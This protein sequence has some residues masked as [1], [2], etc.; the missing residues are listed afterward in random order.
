MSVL[1]NS[2]CI[3]LSFILINTLTSFT[4]RGC[5]ATLCK[6]K[7][8]VVIDVGSVKK[9][10]IRMRYDFNEMACTKN[11][12]QYWALEIS[13]DLPMFDI[14][15][16]L[17]LTFGLHFKKQTERPS[18]LR[19]R[20]NGRT[21]FITVRETPNFLKNLP[22]FKLQFQRDALLLIRHFKLS[23]IYPR[24]SITK[25]LGKMISKIVFA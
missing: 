10:S 24:N 22:L 1:K 17:L 3:R 8:R 21:I 16:G 25:E 13:N 18:I 20:V 2:K 6:T 19:W 15:Y 5:R 12:T 7:I 23:S 9:A 11:S 4:I 14:K